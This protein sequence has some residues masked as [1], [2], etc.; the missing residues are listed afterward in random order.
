MAFPYHYLLCKS[1]EKMYANLVSDSQHIKMESIKGYTGVVVRSYPDDYFNSD[2]LS[3][4]VTEEHRMR[5]VFNPR[6]FKSPFDYWQ[7][8]SQHIKEHTSASDLRE[9]I[10]HNSSEANVF[11]PMIA[12]SAFKCFP[13]IKTVLDPCAGWGDRRIAATIVGLELYI[14]YDTN[15]SLKPAYEALDTRLTKLSSETKS[16]IHFEPFEQANISD[17]PLFDCVFT[18]P[19][20][21]DLEIYEGSDT[22]TTLYKSKQDWFTKFYDVLLAKSIKLIKSG[23]YIMLYIPD[24][25]YKHTYDFLIKK[26]CNPL[27]PIG[28]YQ[29]I[30]SHTTVV[31][32]KIRNLYI[33]QT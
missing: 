21:F 6:K 19:P 14:G 23:G 11:N 31:T 2:S 17:L 24:Y 33:W 4:H 1:F 32:S 8:L 16:Q 3:N 20:F 26:H 29:S 18:S 28:F 13:Q 27:L 12:I 22:S 25:M 10:Y 30:P 15:L 9:L 5:A 7:Q